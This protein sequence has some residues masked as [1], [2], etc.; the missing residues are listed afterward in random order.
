MRICAIAFTEKGQS[1][2]SVLGFPVERGV[3]VMQWAREAFADSDALLFIGACG[4]AVRAIAPL[5]RDKTVDPAVLV[6]DEMGRH[7]IP[8]LSGH[9][10]GAND[11][12]LL[13]AQK[14]GAEP[15]LTTATDVRGIPAIDS[16]AVKNNCAIEN[17]EAIQA[18]SSAALAGKPVGVAITERDIR[19]PFPVTLFLRPRTLTVGVGCKRGT[20]AAHLERCFRAFLHENGV[21]PL[22]VRAVATID[23][24]KDE[25]A[26]LALCEKYRFPLQTYSAAELNAVPGVFAHSDFVMKTVGCGCVCERAAVLASGGR[27]LVGKTAMEGV[28]LALAGEE[29]V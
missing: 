23:I 25:A 5:C 4:I 8:I 22:A 29:D 21:S 19:P 12:A 17:K 18:V 14:T 9:I 16:W 1:W 3:P 27:L 28:T 7:I 13:L 24:K 26:I 11:L 2:Q 15:V 20:D 10:G 6:M